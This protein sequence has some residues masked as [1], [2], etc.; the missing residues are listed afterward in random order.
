MKLI[1]FI[2][3]ILII[4]FVF[5]Q[6]K[7]Y[8]INALPR[9][10]RDEINARSKIKALFLSNHLETKNVAEPF[11]NISN[12]EATVDIPN[13][14]IIAATDSNTT[15]N[16]SITTNSN[17]QPTNQIQEDLLVL[18]KKYPN[19]PTRTPNEILH[20]SNRTTAQNEISFGNDYYDELELERAPTQDYPNMQEFIEMVQN[21]YINKGYK[22]NL[23]NLPVTSRL[24]AGTGT[25]PVNARVHDKKYV[26]KIKKDIFSWNKLFYDDHRKFHIFPLHVKLIFIKETDFE[27]MLKATI[28]VSFHDNKFYFNVIY[29][30]TIDKNDDI[31]NY[32]SDRIN[33]QLISISQIN[34]SKFDCESAGASIPAAVNPFMTMKE[35]LAYVDKINN[36]HKNEK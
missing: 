35:Q 13:A 30:G 4:Y 2:I 25:H 32:A 29:Y 16:P 7:V 31:I 36:M 15:A 33:L 28:A 18:K 12:V 20:P 14:D 21:I 34:K 27:F 9:D 17:I 26:S 3:I 11:A 5:K 19:L 22:F 24:F 1:L 10:H 6:I 8:H 23:I